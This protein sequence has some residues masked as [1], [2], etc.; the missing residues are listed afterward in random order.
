[1]LEV[2]GDIAQLFFDITNDFTFGCGGEGVA[3]L[4]ED[5]HQVV[6]QV[7]A[8]EIETENGVG[9]GIS[10]V[11]WDSMGDTIARVQNDTG[12]TAGSVEGQDGLDGDVHGGGVEGLEHDLGHLLTVG[13]GVEWGLGQQDWVLLWGDTQLVVES[14][15][16]DLLHIV[17]VGDDTVLDWVL[18]GQ[19]TT[20]GLGLVT[21]VGVLLAHAD[22]DTLV[23]GSADN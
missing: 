3:T 5:F 21:D 2:E 16:P 17:P 7:T 6:G 10:L 8:G 22:H 1:M 23:T 14:V 19:N 15:M 9:K 11:D 20:L 18:Q 12:G 13:L 4:G